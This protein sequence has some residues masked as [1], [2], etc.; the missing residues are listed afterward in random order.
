VKNFWENVA[1]AIAVFLSR[2]KLSV[3]VCLCEYKKCVAVFSVLGTCG[4]LQ[5][6]FDNEESI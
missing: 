5:S 4:I 3:C 1:A 2:F 6:V